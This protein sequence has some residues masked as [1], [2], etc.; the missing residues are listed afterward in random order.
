LGFLS[1]R[2]GR[3]RQPEPGAAGVFRTPDFSLE[4]PTGWTLQPA[5]SAGYWQFLRDD[6]QF[7]LSVSTFS[8]T[9]GRETAVRDYLDVRLESERQQSPTTELTA[10]VYESVDSLTV[11]RYGG[12]DASTRRLVA[13]AVLFD[14]S[15]L[16]HLFLEGYVPRVEFEEVWGSLYS[17]LRLAA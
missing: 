1:D 15:R 12:V 6:D 10:P 8:V 4:L 2:F 14:G 11:A 3:N 5:S 17:S 16:V 13:S 9:E 7:A